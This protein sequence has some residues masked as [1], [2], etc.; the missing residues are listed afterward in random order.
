[1][2]QTVVVLGFQVSADNP[3]ADIVM[4]SVKLRKNVVAQLLRLIV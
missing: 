4:N 2:L 1:M 3:S